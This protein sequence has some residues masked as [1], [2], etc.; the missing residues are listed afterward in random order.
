MS[1][2]VSDFCCSFGRANVRVFAMVCGFYCGRVGHHSWT[3]IVSR[4]HRRRLLF[5]AEWVYASGRV[6]CS[7]GR[8]ETTW[9][10]AVLDIAGVDGSCKCRK[11]ESVDASELK[12]KSKL[13]KAAA[14]EPQ[15]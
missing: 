11:F 14:S 15:A 12:R 13:S 4:V 1:A 7:G 5:L 9:R 3:E 8:L 6:M 10:V 2:W